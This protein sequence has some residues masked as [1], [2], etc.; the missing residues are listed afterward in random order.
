MLTRNQL[1]RLEERYRSERVL[2]LYVDG[3]EHDPGDRS[4]WRK[5]IDHALEG[6]RSGLDDADAGEVEAFEA[7]ADYLRRE[8]G[9]FDAY[10]PAAG[11]MGVATGEEVAY[12]GLVPIRMPTA[13]W[14]DDGVRVAPYVRALK[15]E[16]PVLVALVD[17]RRA[18]LFRYREGELEDLADR[19]ADTFLGDLSDVTVSQQRRPSHRPGRGAGQSAQSGVRGAGASDDADRYLELGRKRMLSALDE[20]LVELAAD[21]GW[22]V[23]GGTPEVVKEA[24]GMLPDRL[25]GRVEERTSMELEASETEV[26]EMAEEVASHL[27]ESRQEELLSETI[28]AARSNGKGVLGVDETLRALEEGR[29]HVLFISREFILGSP[30]EAERAVR[31]AF[32]QKAALE[33]VG[34]ETGQRLDQAGGGLGARL[35]YTY[36]SPAGAEEGAGAG[37]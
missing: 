11:W 7:A 5:E 13:A 36:P 4:V 29:V 17:S 12:S 21:D 2:T 1:E 22:I 20:R 14:W 8:L 23:F 19:R 10:V 16:R 6:V 18:R 27:T 30:R 9:A 26:K 33:E 31:L 32:E 15:Q 35:R 37:A 24:R 25:E 34:R 3:G 28:D